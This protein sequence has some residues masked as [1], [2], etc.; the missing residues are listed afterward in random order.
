MAT[1]TK[2]FRDNFEAWSRVKIAAGD[3]SIEEMADLREMIRIDLKPGPDQL[4]KGMEIISAAGVKITAAIDDHSERYKLW[5]EYF[6]AE[7]NGAQ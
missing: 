4:R 3:F 7:L 2:Q 5:D 1:V 6:T